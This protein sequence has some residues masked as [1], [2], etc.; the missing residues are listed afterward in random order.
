MEDGTIRKIANEKVAMGSDGRRLPGGDLMTVATFKDF[1]LSWDW[2]MSPVGN[3]GL[4][5]NVSEELRA[6]SPRTCCAPPTG[7]PGVS[8]SAIGFEYQM[9]DDDRHS[10]GKLPTHRSG[11]LYDLITPDASKQLKPI[12]EWNHSTRGVRR[13]A[14]RALAQRREG[15]GVRAGLPARSTRRWRRASSNRWP[16]SPSVARGTS[17]C[18][19]TETT[20][21]SGT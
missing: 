2:K 1:E 21:G 13:H 20:R 5:Y 15:R 18:R 10:D 11:A 4:K 14:R 9:I 19:I 7:T 17:C 3:S 8:H 12:G 6:G 16:G